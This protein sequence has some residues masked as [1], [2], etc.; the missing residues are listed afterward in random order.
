MFVVVLVKVGAAL[1]F[2]ITLVYVFVVVVVVFVVADVVL[3]VAVGFPGV[4]SILQAI[5]GVYFVD[6]LL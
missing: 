6:V 1:V 2:V 3:V 4:L 5:L